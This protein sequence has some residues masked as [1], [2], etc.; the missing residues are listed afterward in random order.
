ITHSV[1]SR[2]QKSLRD[3]VFLLLYNIFPILLTTITACLML[4]WFDWRIGIAIATGITLY[5]F[6]SVATTKEYY[7]Q[8]KDLNDLDHRM[9][10]YYTEILR[11]PTLIQVQAQESRVRTEH[12]VRLDHRKNKSK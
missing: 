8:V 2:G 6:V 4:M 10:K 1:V 7:P 3:M 5:V 12:A 9:G 11:L